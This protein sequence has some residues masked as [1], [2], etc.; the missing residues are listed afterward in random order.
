MALTLTLKIAGGNPSVGD[1]GRVID[2]D[3]GENVSAAET[4]ELIFKKPS[5]ATTIKTAPDVALSGTQILRFTS[6]LGFFDQSGIWE[7]QARV[8]DITPDPDKVEKSPVGSFYVGR[9]LA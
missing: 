4:L 6:P 1:V 8:T 2:V 5:G 9:L 7:I 3:V